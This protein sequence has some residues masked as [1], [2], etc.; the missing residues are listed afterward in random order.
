MDSL[1]LFSASRTRRAAALLAC[2]GA[3][4]ALAACAS[5]DP[6]VYRPAPRYTGAPPATTPPVY[7]R[8]SPGPSGTTYTSPT[9]GYTTPPPAYTPAPPPPMPSGGG[10]ACGARCG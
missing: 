7:S 10:A 9:P 3:G 2:L 5:E 8:P 1:P 6:N 4:G